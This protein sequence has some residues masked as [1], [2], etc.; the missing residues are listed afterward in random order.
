M[1]DSIVEAN[2]NNFGYNIYTEKYHMNYNTYSAEIKN[3]MII[4]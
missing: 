2:K 3:D 1:T 4:I